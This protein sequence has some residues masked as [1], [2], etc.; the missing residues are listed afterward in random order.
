MDPARILIV[1]DSPAIAAKLEWTL[2][3][4]GYQS[5]GRAVSGKE[6]VAMALSAEPDLVLMDIELEG[7]MT[8][9]QAAERL[10]AEGEFPLVYLTSHA[11]DES[12]AQAQRTA[13]YAY[14]VK[15]FKD[16]EL[17]AAIETA[18]HRH[19]LEQRLKDRES[20]LRRALKHEAV[21]T[22]AGGMAHE[23]NTVLSIILG[24]AEMAMEDVP[25]HW[26]VHKNLEQ[27]RLASLRG[28]DAVRQ[29]LVFMKKP[30]GGKPTLDPAAVLLESIR[31]IRPAIPAHIRLEC[32][33]APDGGHVAG[34]PAQL[35]QVLRNLL[36]NAVRAVR[37]KA[38]GGRIE[39]A[40]DR[41]TV[42][43]TEME[44]EDKGPASGDYFRLRV[45]DD[46][47]G[48][49]ETD[50]ERVFDPYFTTRETGEGVGMGLAVVYGIVRSHGGFVQIRSDPG[51][52]TAVE[53]FLPAVVPTVPA[54]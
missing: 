5:A 13:P 54:E 19:R 50:L 22:L 31:A 44:G 29:L 9:I 43:E 24:N 45:A 15:P 41:A 14:L 46:G 21:C 30:E 32:R 53:V 20:A 8:G 4:F 12:L 6:A 52:E 17:R 49:P 37:D 1:E 39:V 38:G 28:R 35:H 18:L 16:R 42:S 10:R 2:E 11:D 40:L 7:D 36:D 33:F 47:V 27:I 23:F 3:K 48:I 26:P 51:E 34:D 25:S